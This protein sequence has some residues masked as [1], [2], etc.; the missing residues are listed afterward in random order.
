MYKRQE[1]RRLAVGG[2]ELDEKLGPG[3]LKVLE[4]EELDRLFVQDALEI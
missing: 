4:K 1:L 3:G 2:I